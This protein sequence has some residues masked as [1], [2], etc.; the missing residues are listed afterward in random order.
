MFLNSETDYAI[1]IVHFLAEKGER[2]DAKT[3]SEKTGVTIR[4]SLKIL[5][6]LVSCGILKSFKGANGGFV[7]ARAASEITLLE[8]VEEIFGPLSFSRCQHSS[9]ECTHP[10]GICCYSEVFAGVSDFMRDKFR[11]VTF[12]LSHGRE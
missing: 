11:E 7:L 1:R 9:E 4:F 10:D 8:V 2:M 3:I 6:K 12:D 5:H